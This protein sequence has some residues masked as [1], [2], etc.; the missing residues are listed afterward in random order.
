MGGQTW[1]RNRQH[2]HF[3]VTDTGQQANIAHVWNYIWS[4]GEA[5]KGETL[6]TSAKLGQDE[7]SHQMCRLHWGLSLGAA[8]RRIGKS[9]HFSFLF[10]AVRSQGL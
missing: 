6:P 8:T 10:I 9:S 2:A 1:P 5:R 4:C 3:R 7:Q